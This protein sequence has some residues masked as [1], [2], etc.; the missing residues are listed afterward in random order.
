MALGFS[1]GETPLAG[2]W[3]PQVPKW[4]PYAPP[5][6]GGVGGGSGGQQN[7]PCGGA[8]EVPPCAGTWEPA[9][10]LWGFQG[11]KPLWQGFGDRRSPNG[12]FT[13]L[14]IGEGEGLGV[15]VGA[16]NT[17][18]AGEL[19]RYPPRSG[20]WGPAKWLWG[21]Q[22]VKPLWQEFGER[23]SP[24][25]TLTPLPIGEGLGLEVGVGVGVGANNTS[26]AGELK[27]LWGFQGVKPLGWVLGTAGPQVV[28]LRPSPLGRGWGWGKQTRSPIQMGWVIRPDAI[29]PNH[30]NQLDIIWIWHTPPHLKG[31]GVEIPFRPF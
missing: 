23:N 3:G 25:G 18:L 26:L 2:V 7:I 8:K 19:K 10:W 22:G 20:T 6:W 13:P 15:G 17:S 1:R 16:N 29:H 27:R 4:Y 31:Y 28:P 30:S 21:F 14:P 9:K 24:S 12:H 5:H 11:V